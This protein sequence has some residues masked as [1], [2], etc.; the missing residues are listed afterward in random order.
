MTTGFEEELN[1]IK[2]QYDTYLKA[3]NN[4]SCQLGSVNGCRDSNYIHGI[5]TFLQKNPNN[6]IPPNIASPPNIIKLDAQLLELS[7]KVKNEIAVSKEIIVEGDSAIDILQKTYKDK[8]NDFNFKLSNS[9]GANPRKIDFSQE[10]IDKYLYLA[11]YSL[12]IFV[13]ITF[14]YKH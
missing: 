12:A 2:G 4:S 5:R 7:N 6:V 11:Y 13:G 3:G 8:Q 1:T 9:L 10:S 14:L